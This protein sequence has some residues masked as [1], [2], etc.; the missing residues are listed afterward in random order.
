MATAEMTQSH[1]E[2][3]LYK[4]VSKKRQQ[5][6]TLLVSLCRHAI[7]SSFEVSLSLLMLSF[8]YR[9]M[10]AFSTQQSSTVYSRG[11]QLKRDSL[12]QLFWEYTLMG[13]EMRHHPDTAIKTWGLMGTVGFAWLGCFTLTVLE[14]AAVVWLLFPRRGSILIALA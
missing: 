9:A 10:Q 11:F 5:R 8:C 14:I 3:K 13:C 7:D 2:W 1:F 6:N 4:V 12:G